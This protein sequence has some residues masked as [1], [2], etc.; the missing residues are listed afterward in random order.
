MLDDDNLL[1]FLEREEDAPVAYPAAIITI[2]G[3]EVYDVSGERICFHCINRLPNA[4]D[5]GMRYVSELLIGVWC[6]HDY[7]THVL[8]L[9]ML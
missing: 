3:G 8:H 4:V 2:V 5:I 7:P 6:H 9:T 1:C